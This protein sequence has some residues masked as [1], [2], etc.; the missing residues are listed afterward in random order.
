MFKTLYWWHNVLNTIQNYL[1]MKI[2]SEICIPQQRRVKY[3]RRLFLYKRTITFSFSTKYSSPIVN[4]THANILT[5]R[6]LGAVSPRSVAK[7]SSY[8]LQKRFVRRHTLEPDPKVERSSLF[9]I[10]HWFLVRW[11]SRVRIAHDQLPHARCVFSDGWLQIGRTFVRT[12][13][14]VYFWLLVSFDSSLGFRNFFPVLRSC[15]F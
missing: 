2:L 5:D 9:Q 14:K 8:P 1:K 6:D 10:L 4:A 15:L 7:S 13:G 3:Y 12:G 11:R